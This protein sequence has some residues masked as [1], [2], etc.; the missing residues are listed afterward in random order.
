M[1]LISAFTIIRASVVCHLTLAY[2]FLTAPQKI[3]SQNAVLVLGDSMQMPHVTDFDR[4]TPVTAFIAVVLALLA[5]SDFTAVSM[6][7]PL[8]VEY[9]SSITPLRLAFLF[10]FT[11]YIYLF[12]AG[13]YANNGGK[14]FETRSSEL[15]MNS[16]TFTFAFLELMMWFWVF[17]SLKDQRREIAVKVLKEQS[18]A[19]G[20]TPG[21]LTSYASPIS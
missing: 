20:R 18:K 8:A 5:L 13:G 12:K 6:T 10:P 11:A 14:Y 9:W 15:W 21:P 3:V 2:F 1:A 16:F 19:Q 17:V 4:A 7:E